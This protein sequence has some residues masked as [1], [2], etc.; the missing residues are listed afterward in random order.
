MDALPKDKS[1]L[2]LDDDVAFCEEISGFLQRYHMNIHVSHCPSQAEEIL[3]AEDIGIFLLDVMLPEKHGFQFCKEVH[4]RMSHLPIIFI[5]A[6]C[7]TVEQILGF[8]AGADDFLS[9]PVLPQEL[10]ARMKAVLRRVNATNTNKT[11]SIIQTK[12]GLRVD[13]AQREIYLNDEP[14]KLATYQYELLA[15]FVQN[16]QRLVTRA[17]IMEE[18]HS[19]NANTITRSVDINVSRIR[20]ALGET[21]DEQKFIRTVWRKG[22]FF[23]DEII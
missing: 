10:L 1:V 3:R 13:L 12:N 2:I 4:E 15:Y 8:E 6:S 11:N 21:G 7:D 17:E 9:K 23:V 14:L 19:F 16:P 22:Y 20:K 18:I 5:S